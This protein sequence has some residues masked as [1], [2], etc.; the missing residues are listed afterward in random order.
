MDDVTFSLASA[1]AGK[2]T[3]TLAT[4]ARETLVHLR[5]SVRQRFRGNPDARAALEAAQDDPEDSG[6][7]RALAGHITAVERDDS[8]IAE[9][10]G[11]LRPHFTREGDVTN[12]I[13]GEISGTAVQARDI[14]GGLTIE[15]RGTRRRA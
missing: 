12:T 4:S 11:R 14:H 9:L 3:E 5:R 13:E 6:A 15:G 2:A 8:G 1:V 10:V 7:V